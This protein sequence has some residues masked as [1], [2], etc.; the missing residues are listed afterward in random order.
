ML[1]SRFGARLTHGG[2]RR[3]LVREAEKILMHGDVI[4]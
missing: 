2:F 3:E 4:G 1:H